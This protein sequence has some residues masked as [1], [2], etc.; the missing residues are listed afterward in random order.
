[1]D[2]EKGKNK[3]IKNPHPGMTTLRLLVCIIP[4]FASMHK[5]IF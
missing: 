2:K 1:M 3:K 4:Y 5:N